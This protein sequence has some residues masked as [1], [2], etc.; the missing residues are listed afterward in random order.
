MYHDKSELEA[1]AVRKN[2]NLEC[3]RHC[4]QTTASN[5]IWFAEGYCHCLVGFIQRRYV[6]G[7]EDLG[8]FVTHE[9]YAQRQR[10][11]VRIT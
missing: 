4:R 8:L 3:A 9:A 10:E 5:C 2:N 11:Y 6:D 1:G 7:T